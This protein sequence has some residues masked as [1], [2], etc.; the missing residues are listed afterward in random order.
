MSEAEAPTLRINDCGNAIA[1]VRDK[2]S[3]IPWS[4]SDCAADVELADE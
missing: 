3:V 1:R 2:D 4:S